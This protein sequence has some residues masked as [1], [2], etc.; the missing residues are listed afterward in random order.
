MEIS[1][2]KLKVLHFEQVHVYIVFLIIILSLT[3]KIYYICNGTLDIQ[4]QGDESARIFLGIRDSSLSLTHSIG[5]FF[6]KWLDAHP[7]ADVFTKSIIFRAARF[8]SPVEIQD[9]VNVALISTATLFSLVL[10]GSFAIGWKLLGIGGGYGAIA[11]ILLSKRLFIAS[12][13]GMA[14]MTSLP[15]II[16]GFYFLASGIANSEYK[17]RDLTISA[18]LLLWSTFYRSEIILILPGVCLALWYYA[19]LIKAAAFGA[20]VSSYTVSKLIISAL[21]FPDIMQYTNAYKVYDYPTSSWIELLK[22]EFVTQ[23]LLADTSI[24]ITVL[25]ILGLI[26]YLATGQWRADAKAQQ[27]LVIFSAIFL[28][29]TGLLFFAMVNGLTL[30]VPRVATYP[31]LLLIFVQLFGLIS[32]LNQLTR[33]VH[34]PAFIY[35]ISFVSIFILAGVKSFQYVEARAAETPQTYRQALQWLQINIYPEEGILFDYNYYWE[36]Y[37]RAHLQQPETIDKLCTYSYCGHI[38][39]SA[40]PQAGVDPFIH[41][42]H[43]LAHEFISQSNP[44]WFVLIGPQR[45]KQWIERPEINDDNFSAIYPYVEEGSRIPD[46]SEK[47]LIIQLPYADEK[48]RLRQV[49]SNPNVQIFERDLYSEGEQFY[50][51]GDY[52]QAIT[53]FETSLNIAPNSPVL[54]AWL[55][56]V[57]YAAGNIDQAHVILMKAPP[58]RLQENVEAYHFVANTHRILGQKEAALLLDEITLQRDLYYAGKTLYNDGMYADAVKVFQKASVVAPEDHLVFAWLARAYLANEQPDQANAVLEQISLT[59]VGKNIKQAHFIANTY[60]LAGQNEE[61]VALYKQILDA[62]PTVIPVR[63]D[64]V[65]VYKKLGNLEAAKQELEEAVALYKQ[66]LDADPTIIPVRYDLVEVYKKLGNLEAAKQELEAI[67]MITDDVQH[68]QNTKLLLGEILFRTGEYVRAANTFRDIIELAKLEQDTNLLDRV[69]QE[70]KQIVESNSNA[71]LSE[72]ANQLLRQLH[73]TSD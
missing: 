39:V 21:F 71:D 12:V 27:S 44:R 73:T 51:A 59:Q 23:H 5:E 68:I 1:L 50:E 45:Y 34:F 33:R 13:S 10:I 47:M 49:W 65:E 26:V 20:I 15:F 19:G 17:W 58:L 40:P 36:W 14:E 48:L 61:A 67:L 24:W 66:I 56:R 52:A 28:S 37:F 18:L 31:A 38:L 53:A 16:F 32:L 3:F 42:L 35:G 64:L 30:H 54:H 57:Y 43:V 11:L 60:R 29:F 7:P 41:K 72:K 2:L 63:Y 70:L 6:G 8:I 62:D 9:Y 55:A 22:S 46:R 69:R 25:S 4:F